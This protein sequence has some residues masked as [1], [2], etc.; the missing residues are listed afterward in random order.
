MLL[1]WAYARAGAAYLSTTE[2]TA[3]LWAMLLGWLRFGEHVSSFTILGA[4]LIVAGC[5]I[6]ARGRKVDHPVLEATA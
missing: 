1:G 4:A 2:Y 5:L 6:A 3:F